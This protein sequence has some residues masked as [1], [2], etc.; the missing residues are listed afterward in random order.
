MG[1][2]VRLVDVS[3]EPGHWS[4]VDALSDAVDGVLEDG[5]AGRALLVSYVDSEGAVRVWCAGHLDAVTV[6]AA[7]VAQHEI[8]GHTFKGAE[9]E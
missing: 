5:A 7:R 6:L 3:G 9:D 8:E 4:V 2:L 1:R